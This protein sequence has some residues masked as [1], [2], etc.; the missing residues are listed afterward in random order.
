MIKK[1]VMNHHAAV[2]RMNIAVFAVILISLLASCK[3]KPVIHTESIGFENLDNNPEGFISRKNILQ[4]E[5]PQVSPEYISGKGSF[6]I[7]EPASTQH[8]DVLLSLKGNARIEIDGKSYPVGAFYIARIPYNKAYSIHVGKDTTFYC[9][10]F[11]ESLDDA[12][13]AV[14]AKDMEQHSQV[15]IKAIDDCPKYTE[16]IKSAKTVNRMLL[17][18]GMVPRF[19]MG[20]V[21]TEGPDKVGTHIH[22]MLDQFFMGLDS[23]E[24]N[25]YADGAE[26][27][28]KENMLLHIPLASNHSSS[29]DAGKKL[30]YLW[31]DFFKTLEGQKYMNEQHQMVD[32]VK[33]QNN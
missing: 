4:G 1:N 32:T 16:S 6:K 19:C 25:V 5:V 7:D 27:V 28:L 33:K 8:Y 14:I 17:P 15:Y 13:R 12:D 22:P 9:M 20:T 30:N 29:V 23:C 26:A 21:T 10:R 18:E 24:C 31:M 11:R 2:W 3:E